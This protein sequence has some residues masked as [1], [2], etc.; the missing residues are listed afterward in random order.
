VTRH[1]WHD[2]RD[3][4]LDP[5]AVIVAATFDDREAGAEVLGSLDR[6]QLVG[7]AWSCALWASVWAEAVH[8]SRVVDALTGIV[9]EVEDRGDDAA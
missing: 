9:R 6:E 8:G 3:A 2:Q 4:D 5:L 7:V 1:E